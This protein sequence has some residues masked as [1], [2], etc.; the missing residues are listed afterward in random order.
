M[1]IFNIKM[2]KFNIF[3]NKLY[4]KTKETLDKNYYTSKHQGL[5]ETKSLARSGTL[6]RT[7]E[8]K[9]HVTIVDSL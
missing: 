7:L 2:S 9:M 1:Y 6:S 8:W 3:S 4:I 5:S